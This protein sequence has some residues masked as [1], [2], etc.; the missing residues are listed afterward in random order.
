[1][2]KRLYS[3]LFIALM[4]TCAQAEI[5]FRGA[6]IATVANIDWPSKEA[7]G[8]TDKQQTDMLWI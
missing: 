4:Y 3:I 1:M 6:W 8:D 5:T 7:I 2:L